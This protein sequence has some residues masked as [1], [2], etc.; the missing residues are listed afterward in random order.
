MKFG[1]R[2]VSY[3]ETFEILSFQ[4]FLYTIPI[5]NMLKPVNS[6]EAIDLK[7]PE[8]YGFGNAMTA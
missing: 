2:E 7:R 5:I 6:P 1:K 3:N 4:E 8:N